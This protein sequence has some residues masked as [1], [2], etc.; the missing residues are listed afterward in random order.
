MW[1]LTTT[2]PQDQWKIQ[3]FNKIYSLKRKTSTN[4]LTLKIRA[5]FQW[6]ILENSIL[7]PA[8]IVETLFRLDCLEKFSSVAVALAQSC[9]R[10]QVEL[11]FCAKH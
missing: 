5:I 8:I 7:L 11:E 9:L 6:S 3:S 2:R 4:Y 10:R 1:P